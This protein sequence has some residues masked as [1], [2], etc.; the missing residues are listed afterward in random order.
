M[1]LDSASHV[2]SVIRFHL[3]YYGECGLLIVELLV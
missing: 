1:V 2:T 3:S